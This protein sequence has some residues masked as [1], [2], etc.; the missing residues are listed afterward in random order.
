MM[1]EEFSNTIS[2][3]KHDR[4]FLQ[5]LDMNAIGKSSKAGL[6]K[7][8]GYLISLYG[9]DI[10][11]PVFDQLLK[12]WEMTSDEERRLMAILFAIRNDRLLRSSIDYVIPYPL[13]Q[14]VE[15]DGLM[16]HLSKVVSYTENTLRSTAQNIA[17]S[18]KQAGFIEGKVRKIRV[19]P[20][21]THIPVAFAIYLGIQE[22]LSGEF[23]LESPYIRA[24]GLSVQKLSQLL[25]EASIRD[26]INYQSSGNVVT[27]SLGEK[28]KSHGK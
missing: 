16:K 3:G 17:S 1:F 21:I 18:W 25:Y 4:S 13:G 8:K 12:L 22:G 15:I 7:T 28:M 20:V 5:V 11:D 2:T 9:F 23:L 26:Y 14:K 10:E 6:V 19:E 27:I 24:L